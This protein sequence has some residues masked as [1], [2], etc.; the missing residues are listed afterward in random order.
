[1]THDED[2]YN[3]SYSRFHYS[4]CMA[5]YFINRP[6]FCKQM[7]EPHVQPETT[8]YILEKTEMGFEL[9]WCGLQKTPGGQSGGQHRKYVQ[10]DEIDL[11]MNISGLYLV[12]RDNSRTIPYQCKVG[13]N[14]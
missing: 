10:Q 6:R 4:F 11:G 3:R 8:L 9:L 14:Q 2:N 5:Y 1:M 12:R 13:N 7:P